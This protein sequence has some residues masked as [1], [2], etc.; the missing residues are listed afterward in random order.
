MKRVLWTVGC[1]GF[2]TLLTCMLLPAAVAV[3]ALATLR[4]EDSKLRIV[5][6]AY[7]AVISVMA[8]KALSNAFTLRT[9]AAWLCAA[10][11]VLFYFSDL[12]LSL[13][14]FGRKSKITNTLCLATYY[15]A[16]ILLA[17]SLL[18]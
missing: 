5:C 17:L 8:G 2:V 1:A 4:F 11:S 7:A 13:N 9:L 6:M 18:C 3:I 12:M 16:Q 14:V 15:P 10:G